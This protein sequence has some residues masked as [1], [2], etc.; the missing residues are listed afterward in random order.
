MPQLP[1]NYWHFGNDAT[2]G[3]VRANRKSGDVAKGQRVR[4]TG[5]NGKGLFSVAFEDHKPSEH[6]H[7][8][9]TF[10]HVTWTPENDNAPQ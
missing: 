1:L 5:V 4:L 7:K 9:D 3:W 6:W 10:E 2:T 8:L